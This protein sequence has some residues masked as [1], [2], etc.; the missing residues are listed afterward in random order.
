[1]KLTKSQ[2][3]RLSELMKDFSVVIFGAL[4]IG[5]VL[6]QEPARWSSIFLG[7][8]AL[9]ISLFFTLYFQKKDNSNG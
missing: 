5:Q 6:S 2:Y 9:A 8:V 7:T 4:I 3:N 1:M